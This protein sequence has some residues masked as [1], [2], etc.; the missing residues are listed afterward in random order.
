MSDKKKSQ[1][2]ILLPRIISEP[3]RTG[4]GMDENIKYV[5]DALKNSLFSGCIIPYLDSFLGGEFESRTAI[6]S[7]MLSQ[8]AQSMGIPRKRKEA[9]GLLLNAQSADHGILIQSESKSKGS[10]GVVSMDSVSGNMSALLDHGTYRLGFNEKR[11]YI[12]VVLQRNAISRKQFS[13][14]GDAMS[15][16]YEKI[17]M[18]TPEKELVEILEELGVSQSAARRLS[19]RKDVEQ[20]DVDDVPWPELSQ[21]RE[22][23]FREALNYT[24]NSESKYLRPTVYLA[25]PD[26]I[27]LTRDIGR[28]NM[29]AARQ[30]ANMYRKENVAVLKKSAG[31]LTRRVIEAAKMMALLKSV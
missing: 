29:A 22:N 31:M 21:K 11:N 2:R 12:W 28:R 5:E 25:G 3:A 6:A 13:E 14:G 4:F 19:A 20:A 7:L 8:K 9:L 15:R 17:S 30:E 16:L 1:P 26:A 18:E 24:R 23:Q 10:N 27:E